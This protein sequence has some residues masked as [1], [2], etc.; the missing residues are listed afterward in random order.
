MENDSDKLSEDAERLIQLLIGDG[1]G[2]QVS[3]LAREIVEKRESARRENK[4]AMLDELKGRLAKYEK[5]NVDDA[6][7]EDGSLDQIWNNAVSANADA[8]K[9]QESLLS[10][11]GSPYYKALA[12]S[13]G[14][15]EL[16]CER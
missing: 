2:E 12:N 4:K 16:L 3:R 14:A 7:M 13:R 9:F 11:W 8:M 5:D 1:T 6:F 10:Q 15:I